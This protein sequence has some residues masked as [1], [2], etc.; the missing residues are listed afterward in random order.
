V[1]SPGTVTCV[2][3]CKVKKK[4]KI[5]SMQYPAS[6]SSKVGNTNFLWAPVR[7]DVTCLGVA[8]EGDGKYGG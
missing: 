4:K 8:D 3:V 6:G 7:N 2:C 1:R 5:D